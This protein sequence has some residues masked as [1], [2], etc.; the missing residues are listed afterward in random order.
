[1]A[2]GAHWNR[3]GSLVDCLGV[4]D[5][6]APLRGKAP[7]ATKLVVA[8][9]LALSP[10]AAAPSAPGWPKVLASAMAYVGARTQVPLE[11]PRS[12]PGEQWRVGTTGSW[13]MA[14][15]TAQATAT[16]RSYDVWLSNCPQPEPLNSKRVEQT[17]GFIAS[18]YGGFWGKSYPSPSSALLA[19]ATSARVA[20]RRP[21]GCRYTRRVQLRGHVEAE[22]YQ[23]GRSSGMCLAYWDAD[24]WEFV[25]T[26]NIAN[27]AGRGTWPATADQVLA[28]IS[29]HGLPAVHGR[30]RLRHCRRRV[31]Y[32]PDLGQW[33]P[34]L[35]HGD[36]RQRRGPD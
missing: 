33:G 22:V 11:A 29:R 20:V 1:M 34:D 32:Q 12:L 16:A 10:L 9:L 21:S 36:V 14:P 26:T 6:R 8:W 35:R 27:N 18:I 3:G 4:R 24:G 5:L 17:C 23:Y 31:A 19:Q 25:F 7:A 2:G 15:N 13:Q 28:Y 30:P